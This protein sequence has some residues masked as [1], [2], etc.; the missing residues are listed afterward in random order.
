MLACFLFLKGIQPPF[1][2]SYKDAKGVGGET[3]LAT[4]VP[5][6]QALAATLPHIVQ[7]YDYRI[8]DNKL[9]YIDVR[10]LS[11]SM[12]TFRT[13]LDSCFHA[14]K[15]AGIHHLVIDLRQ[16]SGGNTDLGDLL[17]GY[18]TTKKYAWGRKSW[19][20][21]QPYKDFLLTTGDSTATYL[22]HANGTVWESDN[23]CTP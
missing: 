1:V 10:S 16:N 6:R 21:S 14:L 19:K 23:D 11:G 13:W 9:G 3:T 4:G 7:P 17:F 15:A 2:L 20:V 5:L 8:I 12:N 22:Q 18:I